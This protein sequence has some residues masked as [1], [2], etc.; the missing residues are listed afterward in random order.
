LAVAKDCGGLAGARLRDMRR[1]AGLTQ[2]ELADSARVSIGFVRDLE[3]GRFVRP[4]AELVGQVADVLKLDAAQRQALIAEPGPARLQVRI[5]G[6]LMVVRDGEVEAGL[7]GAAAGLLGLLAVSVN[8]T[9]SRHAI[10]DALWGEEPPRSAIGIVHTYVSRLRSVL[11]VS[12]GPDDGLLVRDR[13]G[14]RLDLE[15]DQVDVLQ[16]RR[17]VESARRAR[18]GGDAAQACRAYEQALGWW[19]G[20]PLADI[21]VLRGHPA[22]IALADELAATVLEYADFAASGSEGWPDRV[23]PYLRAL[24]A[25]DRLDENSHA[26]LMMALAAGG[27]QAEALRIYEDLRQRLDGQMGVLP[28]SEVRDVHARILRQE[29]P[30]R[31]ERAGPD[32]PAAFWPV[33]QLPPAPADFTGRSAGCDEVVRVVTSSADHPGV[34]LVAISGPP[35]AGKTTLAL[36]AAHKIRDQFPDGQLWVELA[37]S[38]ARPR[39]PGDVLGEVLRALG[40]SGPAIPGD[41]SERAVAYRSRLAGKR[42]LVVVDDAATAAQVRLLTPG[43]AGCA[44]LVTSRASLEGLDGAHLVPLDVMT[45][46]DAAALL[47]R[48]VGRGRA[49]A[50]PDSVAELAQACGALPL[51][52][53]IVGAKLAARPSWPLSVMV[54]KITGAHDRLRELEAGDLS[55][56]VSIASSYESLPERLRRLFRLLSLLGPSDFAE[57]VASA[58][59]GEPDASDAI[60]ALTA[61]SLLT[62][63]GVDVTGEPRY[64]LHDLLRDYAA[65]RLGKEPATEQRDALERL[66]SAWLQLAQRADGQLPPAPCF[67]P[68]ADAARPTVVSEKAA[69]RLT[70]DP[71]AW[72]SS[73]RVNLVAATEQACE[74]GHLDLARR[75]AFHQSAF[76]Y[77]QDRHDDVERLWLGVA[78]CSD[79]SGDVAGAAFAR[80]RACASVVMRGRAAEVLDQLKA[81]TEV[82][83]RAGEREAAAFACYWLGFCLSD[84]DHF[85]QARREAE[86]GIALAREAESPLAE[87][88]NLRELSNALASL[89]LDDL[90]H[91]PSERALAMAMALGA[92]TYELAALHNLALTCTITGQYERAVSV[93]MRYF[94]LSRALGRSCAEA[95]TLGVLSDAYYGLGR[96]Q[97]AVDSL[98]QALPVFRDHSSGRFHAVCLLKLGYAY[99]AMGSPK[100]AGYLQESLQKFQHLRLPR[101]A[102]QAQKALDLCQPRRVG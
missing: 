52:L 79:R 99:S 93:C 44:L 57:W 64:R 59:L 96:Y 66:L 9:V 7:K 63:L 53:R 45:A 11:A 34:P 67:P 1:A 68:R 28:G 69:E 10:V 90:A 4:S 80:L 77:L 83:S 92:P 89:G 49:G 70:A 97:E 51:A 55:V 60:G 25:R 19:R 3:Q 91:A 65:E 16:F 31:D 56:R 88:L 40:L 76:Q 13:L 54:G 84:L 37:G 74:L 8:R 18:A 50:E 36:Y 17:L 5:L 87:L 86:R 46:D 38:S 33:F 95:L 94:E 20:E 2:R 61:R 29:I 62:P 58:L 26:R 85:E 72:F 24:A 78:A 73:E 23:L 82:L 35:G 21:D 102:E 71:I 75:L 48:I 101:K 81:C 6:P 43:T 14:Y 47:T 41:S 15:H 98:L 22:V 27:R 32:R 100:A 30:G 12:A 42:I 39:E